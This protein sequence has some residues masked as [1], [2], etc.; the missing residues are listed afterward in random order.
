MEDNSKSFPEDARKI[1]SDVF[2]STWLDFSSYDLEDCQKNLLSLARTCEAPSN[3]DISLS[4]ENLQHTVP[5]AD[6][7]LLDSSSRANEEFDI[8]EF[9]NESVKP[10]TTF[11][12]VRNLVALALKPYP[13]YEYCASTNRSIMIGDDSHYMPFLPFADDSTFNHQELMDEYKYFSWQKPNQDPD[14]GYSQSNIL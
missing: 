7:V 8:Y 3:R 13:S 1:I 2:R 11:V 5:F 14:C 12:P 6:H 4:S 9:R 10:V